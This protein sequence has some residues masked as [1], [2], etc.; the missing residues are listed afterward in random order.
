MQLFHA[1]FY[2]G[3]K[4]IQGQ[5]GLFWG[6]VLSTGSNFI[7]CKLYVLGWDTLISLKYYID[8]MSI[9][10]LSYRVIFHQS[11]FLP[12]NGFYQKL[13]GFGVSSWGTR[14]RHIM[15]N[16][17]SPG[18]QVLTW[19][20]FKRYSIRMKTACRCYGWIFFQTGLW[21]PRES[22]ACMPGTRDI[23]CRLPP[24]SRRRID[25]ENIS[26][27]ASREGG[28]KVFLG[29]KTCTFTICPLQ[30][31]AGWENFNFIW[32]ERLIRLDLLH[33]WQ[34]WNL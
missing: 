33:P 23:N 6:Q 8:V 29:K 10:H 12:L 32:V 30:L 28:L 2:F 20:L 7:P 1:Q 18:K 11:F 34:N 5:M 14:C 24:L 31:W 13:D 27:L 25:S 26:F 16:T 21:L 15:V 22:P 19:P 3:A 9:K 17:T 4:W